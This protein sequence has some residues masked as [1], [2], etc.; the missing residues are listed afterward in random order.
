MRAFMSHS[1]R[2]IAQPESTVRLQGIREVDVESMYMLIL[3]VYSVWS[4]LD[5]RRE[6]AAKLVRKDIIDPHSVRQP[7]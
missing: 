2:H 4:F 7:L 5:E 6:L 3:R 1:S